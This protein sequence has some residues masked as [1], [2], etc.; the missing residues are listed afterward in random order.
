MDVSL[1]PRT[2]TAST[3]ICIVTRN[4][5]SNRSVQRCL[6]KYSCKELRW[7][8]AYHLD[9]PNIASS[10]F[11]DHET[12]AIK[13]VQ[14]SYLFLLIE[15]R[16]LMIFEM[17]KCAATSHCVAR[18]FS[19]KLYVATNDSKKLMLTN[20]VFCPNATSSRGCVRDRRH[21]HA[22]PR[23]R[24]SYADFLHCDAPACYN[25]RA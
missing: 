21:C 4:G 23:L 8:L 24:W 2:T 18:T 15:C 22:K 17:S 16:N 14:L 6:T 9:E 10:L 13:T 11:D 3:L 5:L 1:L 12:S 20:I 25:L 19:A 7:F